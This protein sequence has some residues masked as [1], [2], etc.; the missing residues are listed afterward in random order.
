M[1]EES[2]I[3]FYSMDPNAECIDEHFYI[4]KSKFI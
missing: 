2:E 4:N 3:Q 1:I